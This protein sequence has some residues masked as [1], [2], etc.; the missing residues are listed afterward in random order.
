MNLKNYKDLI[1]FILQGKSCFKEDDTQNY[2]VFQW[3]YKYFKKVAG[4]GNGGYYTS[5]YI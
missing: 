4:V 1:Q 2:V 3:V 5:C